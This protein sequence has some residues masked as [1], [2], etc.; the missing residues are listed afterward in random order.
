MVFKKVWDGSSPAKYLYLRLEHML[1]CWKSKS[2]SQTTFEKKKAKNQNW[3]PQMNH[4]KLNLDLYFSDPLAAWTAVSQRF[5][6]FLKI[7]NC[8]VMLENV[9]H[10]EQP[11]YVQTAAKIG[12]EYKCAT[13]VNWFITWGANQNPR[14]KAAAHPEDWLNSRENLD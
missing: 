11:N 2:T 3:N 14:G 12:Q 6:A 13:S 10:S 1:K 4:E 8:N 7:S 9:L 5:W